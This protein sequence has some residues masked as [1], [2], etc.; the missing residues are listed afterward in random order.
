MKGVE[1]GLPKC[2]HFD[3]I[4]STPSLRVRAP[5]YLVCATERCWHCNQNTEVVSLA[6]GDVEDLVER[7]TTSGR[8]QGFFMLSDAP[9]LPEELRH[10]V[11]GFSPAYRVVEEPMTAL[12]LYTNHCQSCDKKLEGFTLSQL[13]YAFGPRTVKEAE[14][15]SVV[16]LPL[17][18]PYDIDAD[19]GFMSPNLIEL[20]A[21]R[22][23]CFRWE[24]LLPTSILKK[25]AAAGEAARSETTT[26]TPK[27]HGWSS[28]PLDH[29]DYS[30]AAPEGEW[31]AQLDYLRWGKS[32]NLLCYF[33]DLDTGEKYFFSAFNDA[34]YGP[35][36]QS[37]NFR[38]EMPGTQYR[39]KTGHN[40]RGKP[41]WLS[42]E[43]IET[44]E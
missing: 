17:E 24:D 39:V 11:Q 33:T 3:V 19:Y 37:I 15:M 30:F 38:Y 34:G 29:R 31:T 23:M 14:H 42:A 13:G 20:Y 26:Q 10:A 28:P 5:L 36:D 43:R 9:F 2:V 4:R 8:Y 7:T 27:I 41:Y 44:K 6:A 32:S 25:E 16:D 22:E 35:R 12:Y 21:K 40:A 18:G 1:I